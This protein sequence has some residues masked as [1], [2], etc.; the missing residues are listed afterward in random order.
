[1]SQEVVI[2]GALFSDVPSISVPDHNGVYHGFTD[3][4]DTTA[5]ASDVASGKYFYASDGTKT[6][7]T[8]SGGSV[9]VDAL[10]VT[11][12]GTY[13]AASGHAYSP[14]TVN[15]SGGGSSADFKA[16][17]ERTATTPTLPSDLTK[18]GV[19]A[20]YQCAALAL[21]S[22]PSGVTTI[23]DYAFYGCSNL[24]LTSLP[25]G[26]TNIGSYAFQ[27]C[28]ALALTSLPSTVTYIGSYAFNK[29]TGLVSLSCDGAITTINGSAFLGSSSNKMNLEEVSFPNMTT[30]SLGTAFGYTTASQACQ[31]LHT[32]DIGKTKAIGGSAFANCYA[33]TTLVLRRSDAICALNNVNAFTNTPMSGYSGLTGTVYVPSALIATYK[34]ASNWKTLYDGGTL[35]FAA[36]EGSVWELS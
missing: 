27:S 8:A 32:A 17:I 23:G 16:V 35:T 22:L 6:E 1:M 10:S 2:A 3:V 21:T 36:I 13:T 11:Q 30:A 7:G 14:V 12:N 19:Y 26:V 15:V 4:S 18:V 20:F 29:C 31:K 34:T 28:A 9:Q 25:S 24:A 33:L 5:A